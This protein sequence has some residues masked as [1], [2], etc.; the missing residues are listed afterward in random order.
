MLASRVVRVDTNT[1]P[2]RNLLRSFAQGGDMP[3]GLRES[4]HRV[5]ES[6]QLRAADVGRGTSGNTIL[7]LEATK[8]IKEGKEWLLNCGPL[9]LRGERVLRKCQRHAARATKAFSKKA[10]A[11]AD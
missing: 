8:Q 2:E 6:A 3:G 9:H 4:L 7:V 1:G 10:R 11:M 5:V